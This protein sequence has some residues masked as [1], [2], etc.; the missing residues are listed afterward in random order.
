MKLTY[1][2]T[3]IA[4]AAPACAM[5]LLTGCTGHA[6]EPPPAPASQGTSVSPLELAHALTSA[7]PA[8]W[9]PRDITDLMLGPVTDEDDPRWSCVEDGNRICGPPGATTTAACWSR[10]GRATSWSTRPPARAMSTPASTCRSWKAR[11]TWALAQRQAPTDPR[12]LPDASAPGGS[13]ASRP[14]HPHHNQRGTTMTIRIE[15]QP[16]E[17][18]KYVVRTRD[19][20]NG[21]VLLSSTSQGYENH[22]EALH[23]ARRHCPPVSRAA[24]DLLAIDGVEP[25]W[26]DDISADGTVIDSEQLR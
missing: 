11:R 24:R 16:G 6:S 19:G 21:K 12:V 25:V 18:G 9:Q 17:N 2:I 14:A 10:R 5:A 26:L 4:I 8:A 23:L 13:A 20:E 1:R 7:Q 3:T 15:V 22:D